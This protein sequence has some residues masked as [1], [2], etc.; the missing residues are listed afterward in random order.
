MRFLT[1]AAVL[2]LAACAAAPQLVVSQPGTDPATLT[3][4]EFR[5]WETAIEAGGSSQEADARLGEM[6]RQRLVAK[7]YV[8]AA[9]GTRPDFIM[10][11]RAAMF[12]H[13]SERD[14][15][16]PVRDPTTILGQEVAFD[17]AGSEGLVREGT[18]VLMAL[19]GA[20]D[21]VLWQATASGATT[22]RRE[23]RRGILTAAGAML[24]QF[25]ARQSAGP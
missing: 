17:P 21:K 7:G 15:Y 8:P 20:D 23:F 3:T 11:Y 10:T 4:F 24:E 22:T 6:V 14:V 2:L 1:L 5:S 16:S 12:V 13:E 19:S 25:P 18:F 9:A